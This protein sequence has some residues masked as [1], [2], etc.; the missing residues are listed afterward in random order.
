MIHI[1]I[2]K[3]IVAIYTYICKYRI[4]IE[5]PPNYPFTHPRTYI[6]VPNL[7]GLRLLSSK[8]C[9]DV[10]SHISTYIQPFIKEPFKKYL[11]NTSK[12][13]EHFQELHKTLKVVEEDW[14][15][16]IRLGTIIWTIEKTIQQLHSG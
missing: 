6:M 3:T 16:G 8:L 14:S 13:L 11:Y 9:K 15:P 5:L 2:T 1:N 4:L 10:L 12:H 7:Y